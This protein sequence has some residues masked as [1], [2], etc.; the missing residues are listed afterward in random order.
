MYLHVFGG[1]GQLLTILPLQAQAIGLQVLKNMVQMGTNVEDNAFVM[2]FAGELIT[3]IF[4]MMQKM[5]KVFFS[6]LIRT[7]F[8]Y[9]NLVN[10]LLFCFLFRSSDTLSS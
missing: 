5:L 8:L 10:F 6:P 3:D 2:F 7:G 9:R 1:I 4:V